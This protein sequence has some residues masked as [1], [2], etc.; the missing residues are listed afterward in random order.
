MM[1]I[2]LPSPTPAPTPPPRRGA[3]S[4]PSPTRSFWSKGQTSQAALG[5]S[6]QV[7]EVEDRPERPRPRLAIPGGG[8]GGRRQGIG[9]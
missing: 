4:A 3:G 1:E 8:G 2:S 7:P 5:A 6:S 9:G